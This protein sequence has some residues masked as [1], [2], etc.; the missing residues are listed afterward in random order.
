MA[1]KCGQL[2][3][4][5]TLK[6][7]HCKFHQEH[8]KP[9]NSATPFCKDKI[10]CIPNGMRRVKASPSRAF[11]PG[12]SQQANC[13]S[14]KRSRY[15]SQFYIL[16]LTY[17][18]CLIVLVFLLTQHTYLRVIFVPQIISGNSTEQIS[19]VTLCKFHLKLK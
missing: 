8:H 5:F 4:N 6:R 1:K 12:S 3:N 2:K 14:L 19:N 13:I 7:C 18:S 10:P 15:Y 16:F 11:G 17:V 9:V